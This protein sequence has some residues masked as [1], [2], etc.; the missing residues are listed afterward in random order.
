MEVK[1]LKVGKIY[2]YEA[3]QRVWLHEYTCLETK[4]GTIYWADENASPWYTNSMTLSYSHDLRSLRE[5]TDEEE[6][7]VRASIARGR[8]VPRN[9]ISLRVSGLDIF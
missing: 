5:A 2:F 3:A 4:R 7:W 9:K 6:R 1:D 8:L